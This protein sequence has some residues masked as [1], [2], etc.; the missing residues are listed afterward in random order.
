V[1]GMSE[2]LRIN[3]LRRV[4][5]DA[6]LLT[7]LLCADDVIEWED[8]M[9]GFSTNAKCRSHRVMSEFGGEP[10]NICSHGVFRILTHTGCRVFRRTVALSVSESRCRA[11]RCAP[12]V[13]K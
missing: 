12:E 11:N 7:L 13:R 9:S 6:N 10:E 8:A 2:R 4:T 3:G 1:P 5:D